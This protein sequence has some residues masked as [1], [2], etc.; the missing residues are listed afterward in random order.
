MRILKNLDIEI[1]LVTLNLLLVAVYELFFDKISLSKF[2]L[3]GYKII[4][5]NIMF[6]LLC[7]YGFVIYVLIR[8]T[9]TTLIEY[10]IQKQKKEELPIGNSILVYVSL[11]LI[12][13][14]IAY[15]STV[16]F[17]NDSNIEFTKTSYYG[18]LFYVGFF[19]FCIYV[20]D[21]Y[22]WRFILIQK[23]FKCIAES[24]IVFFFRFYTS[25]FFPTILSIVIIQLDS[26]NGF[27]NKYFLARFF[28]L[29][30][31]GILAF[32][33]YFFWQDN[34][35]TKQIF[36]KYFKVEKRN[37]YFEIENI[38]TKE[39]L[40]AELLS[41]EEFYKDNFFKEILTHSCPENEHLLGQLLRLK[42][43]K[44]KMR[45]KENEYKFGYYVSKDE[46]S[47][48]EEDDIKFEELMS[49]YYDLYD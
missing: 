27:D 42:N 13:F 28:Q 26:K 43:K 41:Y 30:I 1:V 21:W 9:W 31:I 15:P 12:I 23:D 11:L 46:T 25:I 39:K 44:D 3:T 19:V 10:F 24:E 6:F 38:I 8:Y 34:L 32:F 14:L 36:Y 2:P 5:I 45:R 47:F 20:S 35:Q 49:E 48:S 33:A 22:Y 37:E 29:D 7:F 40:K 18:V 17:S 16:I 4:D